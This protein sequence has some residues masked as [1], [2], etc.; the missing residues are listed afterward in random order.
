MY[1]SPARLAN[2]TIHSIQC[3]AHNAKQYEIMKT[4]SMSEKQKYSNIRNRH[5]G[6]NRMPVALPLNVNDGDRICS[7]DYRQSHIFVRKTR[8]NL[9]SYIITKHLALLH[10]SSKSVS[11]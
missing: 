6:E 5:I 8:E 7:H 11:S 3:A 10:S 4:Y 1:S 9:E 2:L